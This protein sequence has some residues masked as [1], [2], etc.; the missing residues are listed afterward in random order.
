MAPQCLCL[1]QDFHAP[2]YLF[3]GLSTSIAK[4]THSSKKRS[5]ASAQE[6]GVVLLLLLLIIICFIASSC[7]INS[8]FQSLHALKTKTFF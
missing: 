8:H 7:L 6:N 1:D 2:R 3:L 4:A 5:K